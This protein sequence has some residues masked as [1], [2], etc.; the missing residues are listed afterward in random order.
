MADI[1]IEKARPEHL[2]AI[3]EICLAGAV[4][5]RAADES[6]N[7]E[8]YR[9]TFDA[10]R[11]APDIE[12]YVAMDEG[13]TVLG[14]YT[15][16]LLKSLSYR[17]RPRMELESVHVRGDQRGNGIGALMMAHAE[18]R[19]RAEGVSLMQLTSNKVRK[20]AHRFYE[21]LGFAQSHFGFK[22]KLI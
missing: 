4:S 20:D 9:A 18:D 5:G 19:A 22:K 3:L 17:G 11:A 10:M 13:G 21:R 6:D 8:N 1:T 14:T 2:T 15:L 7:P 12:I 16:Y